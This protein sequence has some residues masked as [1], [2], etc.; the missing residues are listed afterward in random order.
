MGKPP[1][2]VGGGQEISIC[3]GCQFP[4]RETLRED[5]QDSER[6]D[7][8]GCRPESRAKTRERVLK[9]DRQQQKDK[10]TGGITYERRQKCDTG[11][12]R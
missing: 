8:V 2:A 7:D 9:Y 6:N 5:A 11:G 1:A 4:I 10:Y 12:R 3:D